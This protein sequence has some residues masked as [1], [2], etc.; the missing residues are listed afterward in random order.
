[1][2]QHRLAQ[3]RQKVAPLL[4]ETTFPRRAEDLE[5]SLVHAVDR[6]TLNGRGRPGD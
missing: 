1:M 3:E 4:Q 6:D 2:L 5:N